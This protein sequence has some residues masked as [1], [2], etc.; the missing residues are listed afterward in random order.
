MHLEPTLPKPKIGEACNGC[1]L[2]CMIQVCR[3]GAFVQGLVK[4]LG[5][6]IAGPCPALVDNKNGTY[7]CG[8]VVNPQKYFKKSKY[9][10]EVLSREFAK[11]IGAGQGCDEIGYDEDPEE[12]EKLH[13]MY[14]TSL[15]DPDTIKMYKNALRIIHGV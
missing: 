4:T 15:K 8:V 7:S 2:C 10:P 1:G 14:E 9:R 3:N 12:D 5:D 6:T 11:L 13:H